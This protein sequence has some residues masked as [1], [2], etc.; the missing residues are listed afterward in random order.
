MFFDKF[1][2]ISGD[3]VVVVFELGEGLFMVLHELVDV[4]IFPLFQLVNVDS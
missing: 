4:K 2:V 1:D 3:L